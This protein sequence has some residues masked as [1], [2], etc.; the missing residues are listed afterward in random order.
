[1]TPDELG[2]FFEELGEW[3]RA[4]PLPAETLAYGGDGDQVVDLH[5]PVGPDD[6]PLLLV[7]HGGFWR[8]QY[9]RRNTA[10]LS[11]A[12]AE[13]GWPT[14]NVEYRRLGPG[15]Y[16]PMLED[17]RAARERL[18]AFGT[19]VAIG[20]SAGGHL[21]LWLAAEG[22]VDGAVALGGVCDLEAAFSAGLGE[23]AVAELLG[24]SP[25][26][27]PDAYRDADPAAR[28]PLGRP[29]VLVHGVDDDRVPVDHARGYAE[30]AA[31][32]GDDCRLV[33]FAGDHFMPIDPRSTAWP[34]LVDAVS[35]L[36]ELVAAGVAR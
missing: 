29:Q 35:S 4:R 18:G 7:L 14:A 15:G 33:E 36:S 19:A 13:R 6:R 9:T 26:E 17:V 23:G 34:V 11:V 8:S 30:R 28:L 10:A 1:V 32:A 21:A 16:R 3:A 12:L 20:H 25:D 31:A 22:A 27:V 24:G 5:G 2:R